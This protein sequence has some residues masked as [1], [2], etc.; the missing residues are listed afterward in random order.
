MRRAG[1]GRDGRARRAGGTLTVAEQAVGA[2]R[3][4]EEGAGGQVL[5][6]PP[7]NVVAHGCCRPCAGSWRAAAGG[8][9][10]A[11]RPSRARCTFAPRL[12]RNLGDVTRTV[13]AAP[14]QHGSAE[15]SS[16]QVS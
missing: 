1:G 13:F 16:R 12:L 15:G 6:A 14:C 11:M 3:L 4:R 5:L 2:L 8:P 9:G 7:R 10:H